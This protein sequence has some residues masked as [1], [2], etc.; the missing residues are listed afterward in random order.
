MGGGPGIEM[1]EIV[2]D[3]ES[4]WGTGRYVTIFS[5][6]TLPPKRPMMSAMINLPQFQITVSVNA[7]RTVA[8]LL[9]DEQPKSRVHVQLPW[10]L[11]RMRTHSL[12]VEFMGWAVVGVMLDG[13]PLALKRP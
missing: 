7:N 6:G 13:S 5:K 12:Q 4:D 1:A 3:D 8:V 11:E 9:G 10:G 2:L